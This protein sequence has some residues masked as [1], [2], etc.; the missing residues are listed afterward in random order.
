MKN[1]L[2]LAAGVDEDSISC[3]TSSEKSKYK[4]L[5]ALVYVPLATGIVSVIFASLYFTTHPLIIAAVCL[6][7]GGVVFTIERALISSL[8]P[9][10]L[11]FAVFFRIVSAIAMSLIISEL[12]IM[13]M[14]RDQISRQNGINVEAEMK[15]I[16]EDYE[17]KIAR[18]QEGLKSYGDD[19]SK[20]EQSLNERHPSRQQ[21][22]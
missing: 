11:N 17:A 20:Q 12:L 22:A 6:V 10:T 7:W 15:K 2:L 3:C 18:L 1:L 14:F 13:F 8:R 9:G 5:G 4:T 21:P 16:H 19:L